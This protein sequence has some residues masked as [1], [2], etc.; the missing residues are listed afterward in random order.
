MSD[1]PGIDVAAFL[2][3]LK[4]LQ[5]DL[6]SVAADGSEAS[7]TVELDQSRVG[8]LSRMDAIRSQAMSVESE[9]RRALQLSRIRAAIKRIEDGEF[10]YCLSCGNPIACE[11][12]DIDPAAHLCIGCASAAEDRSG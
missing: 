4:A 5:A 2:E 7:Q 1:A 6:E 3:R 9:R 10:G 12:L 11:R 8:R